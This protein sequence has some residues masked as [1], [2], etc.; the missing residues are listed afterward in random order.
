MLKEA[1]QNLPGADTDQVVPGTWLN[2]NYVVL[3]TVSGTIL[4]LLVRSDDTSL[5]AA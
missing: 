2:Y 5:L 3:L 1:E 4:L